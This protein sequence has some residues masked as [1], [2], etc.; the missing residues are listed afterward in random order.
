MHH[1]QFE[2]IL[3]HQFAVKM[4]QF[5]QLHEIQKLNLYFFLHKFFIIKIYLIHKKLF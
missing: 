5:F 2:L 3:N 1:M 4:E